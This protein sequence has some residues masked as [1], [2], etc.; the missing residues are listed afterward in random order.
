MSNGRNA[1]ADW[2]LG[3][4]LT[5]CYFLILGLLTVITDCL[6]PLGFATAW[7]LPLYGLWLVLFVVALF[8]CWRQISKRCVKL[9]MNSSTLIASISGTAVGA[10][11][12]G[13]T[14][15]AS[16]ADPELLKQLQG[17]PSFLELL[18]LPVFILFV[19]TAVG[20]Y[21]LLGTIVFWLLPLKRIQ[22]AVSSFVTLA[23][24]SLPV[25]LGVSAHQILNLSFLGFFG[26]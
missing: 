7:L 2:R 22:R 20:V 23:T 18:G 24:V 21:T 6:W 9:L 16:V 11:L 26:E 12:V 5:W 8:P 25:L 13:L 10:V 14:I 15:V 3:N 17:N 4:D 19:T 1:W